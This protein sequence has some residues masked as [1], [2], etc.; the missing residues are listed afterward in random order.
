MRGRKSSIVD[1]FE[2][3][4]G[5]DGRS[6]RERESCCRSKVGVSGVSTRNSMQVSCVYLN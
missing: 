3:E 2:G 5:G 4:G 1:F 6:Q